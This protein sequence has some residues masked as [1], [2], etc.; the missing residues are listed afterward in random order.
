MV[1]APV[2]LDQRAVQREDLAKKLA[3][4]KRQMRQ[5]EFI[6]F[7]IVEYKGADYLTYEGRPERI[8]PKSRILDRRFV[9][10]MQLCME[11]LNQ[12]L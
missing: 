3:E 6:P 11:A 9:W 4:I 1:E 12:R 5:E 2:A 10:G 7:L 8:V